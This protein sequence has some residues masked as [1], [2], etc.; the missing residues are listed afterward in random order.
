MTK[1]AVTAVN[2]GEGSD[3][4]PKFIALVDSI[5]Q[6]KN[7]VNN[8]LYKEIIEVEN[9]LGIMMEIDNTELHA[10]DDTG[11]YA[12]QMNIQMVNIDICLDI[13]V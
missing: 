9:Q 7:A 4:K 8:Y 2:I 10:A 3:F 5:F 13:R 6:A 11:M 1:F 12:I